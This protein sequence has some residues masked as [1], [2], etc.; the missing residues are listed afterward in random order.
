MTTKNDIIERLR[1]FGVKANRHKTKDDLQRMLKA[2]EK[3][4]AADPQPKSSKRQ[5]GVKATLYRLFTE[6]PD[7]EITEEELIVKYL[8]G[9]KPSSIRAWIGRRG[10]GSKS[11]GMK[12]DGEVNPVPILRDKAT[13]VLRRIDA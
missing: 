12:V 4:K 1:V 6:N 13:G 3:R 7:L 2:A 11:Y 5:P 10:L 8:P 9:R